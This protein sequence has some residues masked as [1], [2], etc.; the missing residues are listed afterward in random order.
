MNSSRPNA[1]GPRFFY[2]WWMV[3]G[4]FVFYFVTAGV[5]NTSTV[6]FKALTEEFGWSRGQ[7]A[8][9]FSMGY[10][11]AGMSAPLWGRL[12]DRRGPRAALVPATLITSAF[13][14]VL[15]LTPNLVSMYGIY[16]LFTF[17][18]AGISIIPLSVL[19]ASWFVRMRGRA[20]GIAYTGVGFGQLAITP[21]AGLLV[22][23]V[24]W[25]FGYAVFGAAMLIVMLPVAL[26]TVNRP[27]DR[28]L[29]PD[30]ATPVDAD[31]EP[32][33][34][35]AELGF[36]IGVAARTSSFWMIG[37]IWLLS[38]AA[39]MAVLLHQVPLMT[40]RGS[41]TEW[42]SLVAGLLGGASSLGRLVIGFLA[43]RLRIRWLYFG[44]YGIQ[45]AGVFLLWS[46][47]ALGDFGLVAYAVVFGFAMG[48]SASISPLLLA[49]FYGVR[50]LGGIFGL[51]AIGAT[52]GGALGGWGA[53]L[54]HDQ[55]GSYDLVLALCVAF[56][57]LGMLLIALLRSPGG[58]EVSG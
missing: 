25:R 17:G 30:G 57:L 40:D 18:A 39:I 21:I 15:A 56:V 27:E 41:S 6:F 47:T 35:V 8:G 58:P 34:A 51:L 22:V 46:A 24:G 1:S 38:E 12:T 19:L 3:G 7:L 20:I 16:A 37:A 55:T 13:C 31:G 45:V 49:E 10:L 9:V 36:E 44:C 54:L 52:L 53:G 11:V 29:L 48:G 33:P 23:S 5:F 14:M 42:A 2:G 28:G 26:W 32:Q 50:S 4:A 43:E